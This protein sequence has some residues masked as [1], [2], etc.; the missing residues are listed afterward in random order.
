MYYLYVYDAVESGIKQLN[1]MGSRYFWLIARWRWYA[2]QIFTVPEVS[3]VYML[4]LYCLD[5]YTTQSQQRTRNVVWLCVITKGDI[6]P[7]SQ[8]SCIH[9][10][11]LVINL[12][13]PNGSRRSTLTEIH[14]HVTHCHTVTEWVS[15][16]RDWHG[17][18][19]FLL[20]PLQRT[21]LRAANSQIH[22][23]ITRQS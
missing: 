18:F 15:V 20:S 6:L 1:W 17:W 4:I 14:T 5:N 11:I 22:V 7:W 12:N 8:P 23:L 21:G 3:I 16:R 10:W 19:I 2:T 9:Q 13:G